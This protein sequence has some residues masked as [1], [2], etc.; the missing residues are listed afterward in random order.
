MPAP[1]LAPARPAAMPRP[2][3]WPLA[4]TVTSAPASPL[5]PALTVLLVT[6]ALVRPSKSLVV[7]LIVTAAAP[8]LPDPA[9]STVRIFCALVALTARPLTVVL[10]S[11][12]LWSWKD[13]LSAPVSMLSLAVERSGVAGPLAS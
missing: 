10:P 3:L 13:W 12:R 9:T 2:K 7:T 5:T 8:V 6:R 1:W 11:V 4:R